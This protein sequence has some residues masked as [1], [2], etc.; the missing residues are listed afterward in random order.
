MTLWDFAATLPL[1]RLTPSPSL[2]HPHTY[3]HTL[4]YTNGTPPIPLTIPCI[5]IHPHLSHLPIPPL[6][7][8]PP[9]LSP[10][11][12]H[13]III[14]QHRQISRVYTST[15][16]ITSPLSHLTHLITDSSELSLF[17][18]PLDHHSLSHLS[19]IPITSTFSNYPYAHVLPISTHSFSPASP[20]YPFPYPYLFVIMDSNN[21]TGTSNKIEKS[22]VLFIRGRGRT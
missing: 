22:L 8:P 17:K 15:K 7:S 19:L 5:S 4:S 18:S 14:D 1:I 11:P 9:S 20:P 10:D 16:A 21:V 12:S 2:T 3:T 6:S 13:F